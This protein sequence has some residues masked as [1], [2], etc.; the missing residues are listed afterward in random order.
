MDDNYCENKLRKFESKS[1]YYITGYWKI[2]TYNTY[3]FVKNIYIVSCNKQ[4]FQYV[5]DECDDFQRNV[6]TDQNT[7]SNLTFLGIKKELLRASFSI[8]V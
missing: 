5:D 7:Y 6:S 3:N 4:N 8:K 2:Y 1:K